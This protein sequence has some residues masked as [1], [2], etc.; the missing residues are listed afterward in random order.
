MNSRLLGVLL[1]IAHGAIADWHLAVAAKAV[2]ATA[3]ANLAVPLTLIA[4]VH[5]VIAVAAW[6]AAPAA[7]G[8][9]L[10]I[11][12]ALS[13]LFNVYEHFLGPEP[14][15]IFRVAPG[16]WAG[17]FRISVFI[18]TATEIIGLWLG[19]RL[20]LGRPKGASGPA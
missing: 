9:L 13:L 12:F 8:R 17:T 7:R 19:A 20:L 14:N 10:S 18:L 6:A 16:E 2:P 3:P 1:V 5:I 4:L 11:F 15:S